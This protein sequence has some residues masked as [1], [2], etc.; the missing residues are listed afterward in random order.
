MP[1]DSTEVALMSLAKESKESSQEIFVYLT[2]GKVHW[3]GVI[4]VRGPCLI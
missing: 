1:F 4:F 3:R 2:A